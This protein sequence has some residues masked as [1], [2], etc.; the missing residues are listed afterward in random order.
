MCTI[1]V[2]R[3]CFSESY[4]GKIPASK[5]QEKGCIF[6]FLIFEFLMI[7]ARAKKTPFPK[8]LGTLK[9]WPTSVAQDS[10]NEDHKHLN[11]HAGSAKQCVAFVKLLVVSRIACSC[12]SG[13]KLT[14]GPSRTE[15]RLSEVLCSTTCI[16]RTDLDSRNHP[17]QSQRNTC[18]NCEHREIK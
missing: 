3:C 7:E 16:R 14:R 4:T 2:P 13:L 12:S 15:P 10:I 18:K 1:Q 11:N 8:A 17:P 5:N 9:E 6:D